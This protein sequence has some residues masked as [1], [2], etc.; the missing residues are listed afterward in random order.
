M[1]IRLSRFL[2]IKRILCL[3]FVVSAV[4]LST[5]LAQA[6]KADRSDA[7]DSRISCIRTLSTLNDYRV[8]DWYDGLS[9]VL[10]VVVQDF[11]A[12]YPTQQM[13]APFFQSLIDHNDDLG[14]KF[15]GLEGSEGWIDTSVLR[16][17]PDVT[18]TQKVADQFLRRGIINGSEYFSVVASSPVALYGIDDPSL[19]KRNA[20]IFFR[21]HFDLKET[22]NQGDQILSY[23]KDACERASH[24]QL[25]EQESLCIDQ[26]AQYLHGS[27]SVFTFAKYL[28][29]IAGQYGVSLD[30]YPNCS[31]IGRIDQMQQQIDM[32][33]LS[34]EKDTIFKRCVAVLSE[35]DKK[36]L[37]T[38]NVKYSLDQIPFSAFYTVLNYFCDTYEIQIE[39]GSEL[40][41]MFDIVHMLD[42]IHEPELNVEFR[43]LV[44]DVSGRADVSPAFGS[45]FDLYMNLSVVHNM[46]NLNASRDDY[47]YYVT[48]SLSFEAILNQIEQHFPAK[49]VQPV[50][51][52]TIAS[53]DHLLELAN[54]FYS[55]AIV[56]DSRMVDNALLFNTGI[57]GKTVVMVGG[58]FHTG[59]FAQFLRQQ[60]VSYVVLSPRIAGTDLSSSYMSMMENKGTALDNYFVGL[61]SLLMPSSNLKNLLY[62]DNRTVLLARWALYAS[63]LSTSAMKNLHEQPQVLQEKFAQRQADWIAQLQRALN[64]DIRKYGVGAIT[65]Q[66]VTNIIDEFTTLLDAIEFDFG[67]SEY[68]EK[69]LF[70]PV[71]FKG[72]IPREAVV[73]VK[74]KNEDVFEIEETLDVLE[75]F[76]PADFEI[77]VLPY[78]S[79]PLLSQFAVLENKLKSNRANKQNFFVLLELFGKKAV[80]ELLDRY[81]SY[82]MAYILDEVPDYQ[83]LRNAIAVIGMANAR[84]LLLMDPTGFFNIVYVAEQPDEEDEYPGLH[85]FVQAVLQREDRQFTQSDGKGIPDYI[86][87]QASHSDLNEWYRYGVNR[88]YDR[89][90]WEEK[91]PEDDIFLSAMAPSGQIIGLVAARYIPSER[92]LFI[93]VLEACSQ[94][95]Y[96]GVG[97]NLV[98]EIVKAS[99]DA[100]YAG[101]VIL[102]AREEAKGFYFQLGF[103]TYDRYPEYFAL[104]PEGAA[105]LLGEEYRTIQNN[106]VDVVDNAAILNESKNIPYMQAIEWLAN[107]MKSYP[108]ISHEDQVFIMGQIMRMYEVTAEQA[109]AMVKDCLISESRY[110]EAVTAL[111]DFLVDAW[112]VSSNGTVSNDDL[113]IAD[114]GFTYDDLKPID[115]YVI[116]RS[117]PDVEAYIS[118]LDDIN[119]MLDMLDSY[120]FSRE[121]MLLGDN[122]SAIEPAKRVLR[123]HGLA[124]DIRIAEP[125][126][127]HIQ[128]NVAHLVDNIVYVNAGASVADFWFVLPHEVSH[129]LDDEYAARMTDVQYIRYIKELSAAFFEVAN[130]TG[131]ASYKRLLNSMGARLYLV[132]ASRELAIMTARLPM[133]EA[134]KEFMEQNKIS[135][136]A[137]HMPEDYCADVAAS[138]SEPVVSFPNKA[139]M[140]RIRKLISNDKLSDQDFEDRLHRQL[141][142]QQIAF[143]LQSTHAQLNRMDTMI[144]TWIEQYVDRQYWNM[145]GSAIPA[146]LEPFINFGNKRNGVLDI[147]AFQR[148]V[149]TALR[150]MEDK[151]KLKTLEHDLSQWLAALIAHNV[152]PAPDI[153]NMPDVIKRNSANCLGYSKLYEAI[154]SQFGLKI[155]HAITSYDIDGQTQLHAVNMVKY[156]D[157][158]WQPFSVAP[159]TQQALLQNI[160]VRVNDNGNWT[161]RMM[162][163]DDFASMDPEQ[164]EGVA[165]ETLQAATLTTYG[166]VAH[167]EGRYDEMLSFITSAYERDGRNPYVAFNMAVAQ[168]KVTVRLSELMDTPMDDPAVQLESLFQF[169]K[170]YRLGPQAWDQLV[171]HATQSEDPYLLVAS[172]DGINGQGGPFNPYIKRPAS[173]PKTTDQTDQ[174]KPVKDASTEKPKATDQP[175]ETASSDPDALMKR[176]ETEAALKRMVL[177]KPA[178][179]VK[180]TPVSKAIAQYQNVQNAGRGVTLDSP[181]L[182]LQVGAQIEALI[183]KQKYQEA[184]ARIQGLDPMFGARVMI[185]FPWIMAFMLEMYPEWWLGPELKELARKAS[186][187]EEIRKEMEK[188]LTTVTAVSKT[189]DRDLFGKYRGDNPL[190]LMLHKENMKKLLNQIYDR[191]EI[192]DTQYRG[193]HDAIEEPIAESTASLPPQQAKVLFGKRDSIALEPGLHIKDGFL[194]GGM[195]NDIPVKDAEPIYCRYMKTVILKHPH[196]T[197]EAIAQ[198]G[199]PYATEE[200]AEELDVSLYESFEEGYGAM[201]LFADSMFDL[202]TDADVENLLR[203]DAKNKD[204]GF[205][206]ESILTTNLVRADVQGLISKIKN[207]GLV[208]DTQF[209]TLAYLKKGYVE[210][211]E[212]TPRFQKAYTLLSV[213]VL[214]QDF[215]KDAVIQIALKLRHKNPGLLMYALVQNSKQYDDIAPATDDVPAPV[216]LPSIARRDWFDAAM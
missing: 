15:I 72:K 90:F 153:V 42:A 207:R 174:Q 38:A 19:Y 57:K 54:Q 101:T 141:M 77:T 52:E 123:E 144:A 13:Y 32:Q 1:H 124:M 147:P 172:I 78:K 134:G 26:V 164:I 59:G 151:E 37:V 140:R 128:G 60:S 27:V 84:D 212:K 178:Q 104:M 181:R 183:Q 142:G 56:R 61:R 169:H 29:E 47:D 148:S 88:V 204:L 100:G 177:Q 125:G 162:S 195:F 5:H 69:T 192:S 216:P 157:G 137:P 154:A 131:K 106:V 17:Y 74:K 86:I 94:A 49:V 129:L 73:S 109:Q 12:S 215:V 87:Q 50:L 118:V 48:N 81:S 7:V 67:H 139:M 182:L 2:E 126:H 184:M 24:E 41:S 108:S 179:L 95:P 145:E 114:N 191:G 65:E 112:V 80:E 62:P 58:G 23:L 211:D 71:R 187:S 150:T 196:E 132:A 117:T 165:I 122:P 166:A 103:S 39:Q 40:A 10:M 83:K 45:V 92:A 198:Y 214:K 149:V 51:P 190:W 156:S 138:L 63:V 119:R 167:K 79:L 8:V 201:G 28:I 193:V 43:S 160:M 18:V 158:T 168:Y 155:W 116:P 202:A 185:Q 189:G 21:I 46:L 115:S 143:S 44:R 93:D 206:L 11:H 64:D 89:D 136:Y 121:D 53:I 130:E 209:E 68:L 146:S 20:E 22:R 199:K 208:D 197:A 203:N 96:N 161:L 175:K 180:A 6:V 25:S 35:D 133:T 120:G 33:R 36:Q 66:T 127:L 31:A 159:V 173:T 210:G 3:L 186:L 98:K 70:I 170:L 188:R 176:L 30:E 75:T 4:T 82:D 76:N 9:D 194:L 110:V 97:T 171:Y 113:F 85:N 34:E 152:Q 163:M 99:L 91:L 55:D 107:L 200:L 14:I 16:S 205:V 135:P 213:L 111:Y 105:E 102:D